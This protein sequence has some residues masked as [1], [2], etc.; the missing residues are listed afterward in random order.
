MKRDTLRIAV[1]IVTSIGQQWR[2]QA[3]TFLE[4]MIVT[5]AKAA[6]ATTS[7][8]DIMAKGTVT[9]AGATREY[10]IGRSRLYDL[11]MDGKLAYSQL[12]SRRLI[13]R[14]AIENLIA[15]QLIGVE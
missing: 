10:G 9:V 8:Q 11:M 14:V 1:S 6:S 7:T 15:A 13:P 5:N 4:G 12:G 2:M 3:E